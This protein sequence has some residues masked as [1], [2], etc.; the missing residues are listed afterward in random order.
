ME[1]SRSFDGVAELYAEARPGYPATL[2]DELA[3]VGALTTAASVLEVGCGAGQA[4]ADLAARAGRVLAIDPGANLIAHAA[5]RTAGAHVTF[6]VT[7]FEDFR[8]PSGSFE[9]VASA[10]AWHWV[11]PAVGFPKA[12]DLLSERGCLAVFGHVPVMPTHEPYHDAFR[13]AFDRFAPGAWGR[14][15]PASGYRPDGP[16]PAL[17]AASGRFAPAIHHAFSWTW[18]LDAAT[19]GKY[20]RTDSTYRFLPEADR[21]ALFD[22]MSDAVEKAGNVLS[23]AWETHLY[24][25]RKRSA[26]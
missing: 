22:E 24:L 6:E 18:T 12:A 26:A 25:A 14:P 15:H 21:F 16:L 10:Q 11:D 20:L 9:L 7:T 13:K 19:F 17:F 2:F 8:A 3:G 4:T 23:L 1:Q 5:Q